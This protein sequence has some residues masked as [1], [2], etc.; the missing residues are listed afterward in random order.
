MSQI[1]KYAAY[2]S[3][4]VKSENNIGF[5]PSITTEE[6]QLDEKKFFS[7][8]ADGEVA[9]G[10]GKKAAITGAKR[11][12]YKGPG[13]SGWKAGFKRSNQESG[14]SSVRKEEVLSPE[15]LERIEAIAKENSLEEVAFDK[16]KFKDKFK[17]KKGKKIEDDKAKKGKKHAGK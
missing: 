17:D 5:T 1:K 15:E 10:R 12:P 3:K 11:N 7:Q 13:K 16:N 9:Q 6:D 14:Q 2:I 4:Q 8:A